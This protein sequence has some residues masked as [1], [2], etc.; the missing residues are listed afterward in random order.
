M[1]GEPTVRLRTLQAV[2]RRSERLG[3][4]ADVNP[5]DAALLH[6]GF[7]YGAVLD[8]RVISSVPRREVVEAIVDAEL[9]IVTEHHPI[10]RIDREDFN[11]NI[12]VFTGREWL[13]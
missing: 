4:S 5:V 3:D 8:A 10:R 11:R 13:E 9:V 1:Q 7:G 2:Y 12:T 6:R